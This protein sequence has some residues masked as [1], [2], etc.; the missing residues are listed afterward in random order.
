MTTND[1]R[2]AANAIYIEVPEEVAND[3]SDKLQ[4]AANRID[5]LE[6]KLHNIIEVISRP[7]NG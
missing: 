7:A 5:K 1:L 3:I 6:Q 4:W 2:K